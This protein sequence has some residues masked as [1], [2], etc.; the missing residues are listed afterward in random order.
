M[1][2]L[3]VLVSSFQV[4][5]VHL[6]N[7]VDLIGTS[8]LVINSF[9]LMHR[10]LHKHLV[11]KF[12]SFSSICFHVSEQQRNMGITLMLNILIL[13]V[14]FIPFDIQIFLCFLYA[15]HAFPSLCLYPLIPNFFVF[16]ILPMPFQSYS[17]CQ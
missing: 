13:V 17:W 4:S 7:I 2:P 10:S 14:M 15:P 6:F 8:S 5:P 3:V 9:Q 11:W 12:A 1:F 16:E